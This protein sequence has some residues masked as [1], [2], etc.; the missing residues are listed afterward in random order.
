[1]ND[2]GSGIIFVPVSGDS[3]GFLP[4][5]PAL[6]AAN[7]K[8]IVP[9]PMIL[10]WTTDDSSWYVN[11]PEDD[12]L[13]F[14]EFLQFIQIGIGLAYPPD[15]VQSIVH[16][17]LTM[18]NMTDPSGLDPYHIREVAMELITDFSMKSFM[19]K[20][21]R[22]F[23]KAAEGSRAKVFVY[24]Y[25]HRPSYSVNPAWQRVTHMD[26]EGMG[27][28]LP[29][30][31]RELSYPQT[32]AHDRKVSELMTTWWSNFAKYGEPSPSWPKFGYQQG[33]QQLM[34][35]RSNPGVKQFDGD[36]PVVLWTGSSGLEG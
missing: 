2:F 22:Q 7:T 34:I 23:S 5:H 25:H 13:T 11:D 3:F 6:L 14:A 26:D 33:D 31:P 21:A 1:M 28:G 32:S 30:G 10:G 35:I 16:A 27:L 9:I 8:D 18:Y 12:G 15:Q 29:N 4:E 17:V 24:E 20:E 19:A 36:D